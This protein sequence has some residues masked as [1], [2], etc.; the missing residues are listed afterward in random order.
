[1]V[2]LKRENQQLNATLKRY[3]KQLQEITASNPENASSAAAK[4]L[5]N[6]LISP[7]HN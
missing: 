1:M 7:S 2:S 4:D 6:S 5:L 3:R